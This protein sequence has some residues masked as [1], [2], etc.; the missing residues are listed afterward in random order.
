MATPLV[1]GIALALRNLFGSLSAVQ[2]RDALTNTGRPV[3]TDLPVGRI[4]DAAAAYAAAQAMAGGAPPPPAPPMVP[5]PP[6]PPPGEPL[7]PEPP[8]PPSSP[9]PEPP[10]PICTPES[11]A[12]SATPYCDPDVGCVIDSCPSRCALD[13]Y[14]YDTR[15]MTPCNPA[16]EGVCAPTPR[17]AESLCETWSG[18]K[19]MCDGAGECVGECLNDSHCPDPSK[20]KCHGLY[21]FS[22]R[23]DR[24]RAADSKCAEVSPPNA[25]CH[26][27][28][29]ML[30]P[31]I[32][33]KH[34]LVVACLCMLHAAHVLAPG[35]G[36]V[37]SSYGHGATLSS[38]ATFPLSPLRA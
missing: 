4:V 34:M 10:P 8:P 17:A 9:E 5:D 36:S 22:S 30:S 28:L 16:N 2:T 1:A 33:I 29:H 11:C 20:P 19:A 15:C 24:V 38:S 3:L 12:G 6:A 31:M 13:P 14:W 26:I 21:P 37:H 25:M 35:P 23:R 32:A 7:T 18:S 27:I